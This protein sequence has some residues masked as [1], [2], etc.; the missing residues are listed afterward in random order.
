MPK[1][2]KKNNEIDL[3]ID[4]EHDVN[5]AI[6]AAANS[7]ESTN[8]RTLKAVL[9]SQAKF[10]QVIMTQQAQVTQIISALTNQQPPQPSPVRAPITSTDV[11]DGNEKA[12]NKQSDK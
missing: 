11:S 3:T 8:D 7:L 12:I 6:L 9:E 5:K 2:A 4:D 1:R 10:M